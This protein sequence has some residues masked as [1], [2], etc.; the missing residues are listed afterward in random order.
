[1]HRF[2]LKS[3]ILCVLVCALVIVPAKADIFLDTGQPTSR[4]GVGL[5]NEGFE[6]PGTFGFKAAGVV[7]SEEVTINQVELWMW[8]NYDDDE[9]FN[10]TEGFLDVVLYA[11]ASGLPGDELFRRTDAISFIPGAMHWRTFTNLRWEVEAGTYWVSVEP[12]SGGVEG[13]TPFDAPN[14]LTL[15]ARKESQNNN[16]QWFDGSQSG[17]LP[18]FRVSGVVPE[19]AGLAA[20]GLSSLMFMRRRRSDRVSIRKATKLMPGCRN[21]MIAAALILSISLGTMAH[22]G[23][24]TDQVHASIFFNSQSADGTFLH[25]DL[26]ADVPG[27][28]PLE[29]AP[30]EDVSDFS[31]SVSPVVF[32]LDVTQLSSTTRRVDWSFATSS[33]FTPFLQTGTL[34]KGNTIYDLVFFMGLSDDGF[35]DPDFSG[36]LSSSASITQ[37]NG[38]VFNFDPAVTT[39]GLASPGFKVRTTFARTLSDGSRDT[40]FDVGDFGITR[41]DA[42]VVYEHAAASITVVPT[43]AATGIGLPV[44]A[45]LTL[46]RRRAAATEVSR[47]KASGHSRTS[48]QSLLAGAFAGVLLVSGGCQQ[49]QQV[50]KNVDQKLQEVTR[51]NQPTNTVDPVASKP[52]T[53]TTN[54]KNQSREVTKKPVSEKQ[55][56]KNK[57]VQWQEVDRDKTQPNYYDML[58]AMIADNQDIAQKHPELFSPSHYVWVTMPVVLNAGTSMHTRPKVPAWEEASEKLSDEFGK[59]KMAEEINAVFLSDVGG[60]KPT[61]SNRTFVFSVNAYV[62]EYDFDNQRFP[63]HIGSLSVTD[64]DN[65]VFRFLVS[66]MSLKKDGRTTLSDG[67]KVSVSRGGHMNLIHAAL[68]GAL[69]SKGA[70]SVKLSNNRGRFSLRAS[71]PEELKL[72]AI[73]EGEAQALRKRV[74]ARGDVTWELNV[75]YGRIE[76]SQDTGTS[77]RLSRMTGEAEERGWIRYTVQPVSAEVIGGQL[78]HID[79]KT[80]G[81]F[82]IKQFGQ[83]P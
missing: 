20:L 35:S 67:T 32:S 41:Y 15:F 82:V 29:F 79:R 58:R 65:P 23:S 74:G 26:N 53:A 69:K 25:V 49:T 71:I 61:E 14:P 3:W 28:T 47:V 57:I 46:R 8:L 17:N 1:M 13:A 33:I 9:R 42:S 78:V 40:S 81:R 77:N 39:T 64:D 44:L 83:A 43:P 63:V 45:M 68:D 21:R 73:S 34:F 59:R 50:F 37:T 72:L 31:K 6:G 51:K 2:R 7:L 80:R 36:V 76:L 22:A 12:L 70:P 54:V 18:G 66:G 75:R 56:V 10:D 4:V 19:P 30:L 60:Y 5:S 48:R 24:V 27:S 16:G 55:P 52:R 62:G 38:N 11:N